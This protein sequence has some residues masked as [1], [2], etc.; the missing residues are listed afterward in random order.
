MNMFVKK[1]A[2]YIKKCLV[3]ILNKHTVEMYF[4]KREL[5][6]YKKWYLGQ[7][8]DLHGEP[9]PKESEKSKG[10][11]L[12]YNAILTWLNVHQKTKYLEDLD[13]PENYFSGMRLLDIGSGPFPSALVFSDCDVYCLDPLLPEYLRAGYPIHVYDRAKFVYAFSEHMPFPDGYFGAIISV[14]AIDHVDDFLKT[15]AEIK[16]VLQSG[17]KLRI[18]A[19]YHR[20]TAAE[21]IEI[22][23]ELMMSAFG[24]CDGFR[25]IKESKTKRGHALEDVGEKYVLWSN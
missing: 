8:H 15:A 3:S 25:K 4:W 11:S 21:P 13:I 20:K 17:G 22:T 23:D 24:W 10:Y 6:N 12:E 19:H 7:V 2:V 18:H 1:I 5:D 16:R 14:N 9:F